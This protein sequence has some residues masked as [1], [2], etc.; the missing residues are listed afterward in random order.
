M[1]TKKVL[2]Y[3]LPAVAFLAASITA[4]RHTADATPERSARP[5][6]LA[7]ASSRVVAEGRVTPSPGT[8]IVVSADFAGTLERVAVEE[9]QRVKK[10]NV[11][12]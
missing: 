11:V 7:A 10:G 12:A 9:K 2:L 4:I 1:T 6:A 5:L 3:A 8:D